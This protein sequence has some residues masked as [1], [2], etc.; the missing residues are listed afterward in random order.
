MPQPAGAMGAGND[1]AQARPEFA[2]P[3][4]FYDERVVCV[5]LCKKVYGN[6]LIL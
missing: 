5:K 2:D 4:A 3:P 1:P 6:W